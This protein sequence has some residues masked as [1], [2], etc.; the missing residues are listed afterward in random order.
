MTAAALQQERQAIVSFLAYC[1]A[2]GAAWGL[3]GFV[4][5]AL[6]CLFLNVKTGTARDHVDTTAPVLPNIILAAMAGWFIR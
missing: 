1:F 5:N 2:C 6:G 3:G 4:A